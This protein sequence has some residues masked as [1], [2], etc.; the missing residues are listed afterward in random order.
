MSNEREI[1]LDIFRQHPGL[2]TGRGVTDESDVIECLM[3]LAQQM[4]EDEVINVEDYV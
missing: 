4:V 1:L 3:L 2:V